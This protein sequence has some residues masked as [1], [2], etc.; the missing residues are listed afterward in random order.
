MGVLLSTGASGISSEAAKMRAQA[1]G[2]RLYSCLRFVRELARTQ[3]TQAQPTFGNYNGYGVYF[4]TNQTSGTCLQYSP[5]AGVIPSRPDDPQNQVMP[6]WSE[7]VPASSGGS[8]IAPITLGQMQP[9]DFQ[10]LSG[11]E[12]SHGLQ[13]VF[14]SD[15]IRAPDLHPRTLPR[16]PAQTPQ[17]FYSTDRIMFWPPGYLPSTPPG[18]P[19]P[20]NYGV[21]LP[22]SPN[23]QTIYNR[24]Y[25]L[26]PMDLSG[27]LDSSINNNGYTPPNAILPVRIRIDPGTGIIRMMTK[28]ERRDDGTW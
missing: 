11:S 27:G 7:G 14:Q 12:L 16:Y 15:Q 13:I 20:Q 2:D 5:L 28:Y 10:K 23:G 19:W 22:T 18:N 25:I 9:V 1:E 21:T 24:V 17:P 6:F 3:S 26:S 4:W 8:L